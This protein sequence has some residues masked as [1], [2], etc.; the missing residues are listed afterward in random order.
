MNNDKQYCNE[1][2]DIGTIEISWYRKENPSFRLRDPVFH[3]MEK[4]FRDLEKYYSKEL[5]C[6]SVRDEMENHPLFIPITKFTASLIRK[7]RNRK[8]TPEMIATI[9]ETCYMR[10]P[11]QPYKTPQEQDNEYRER[12]QRIEKWNK[13]IDNQDTK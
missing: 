6:E 5:K 1:D 11:G 3:I 2:D 9:A 8:I 4:L 12:I 10:L 7:K 13:K